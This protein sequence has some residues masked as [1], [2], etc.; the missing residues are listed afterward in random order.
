MAVRF[1]SDSP[2]SVLVWG[3]VPV[4]QLRLRRF[5]PLYPPRWASVPENSTQTSRSDQEG[6]P[7]VYLALCNRGRLRPRGDA[8]SMSGYGRQCSRPFCWLC[9]LRMV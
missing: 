1:Y 9:V 6:H 4:P 2:V 8:G 5:R 7:A 3:L